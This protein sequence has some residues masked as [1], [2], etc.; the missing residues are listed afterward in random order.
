[1]HYNDYS[2]SLYPKIYK[3]ESKQAHRLTTA[4]ACTTTTSTV[5]SILNS[6]DGNIRGNCIKH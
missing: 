4:E 1:M 2:Y 5:S 3:A 6:V